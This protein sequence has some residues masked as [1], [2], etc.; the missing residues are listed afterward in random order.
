M[1]K[2]TSCP[3]CNGQ[4][5]VE[6]QQMGLAPTVMHEIFPGVE[7]PVAIISKYD[8]CQNCR[9]IFQNPRLGNKEV[10]MFYK[11][12]FY[13]R[14]LNLTEK[15]MSDDE[16]NRA[17]IDSKII[18]KHSGLIRSHLDIGCGRGYLL[19]VVNAPVKIGV[20]ADSMYVKSK[21][22]TL[23]SKISQVKQAS[24][25]LVTAIHVLEHVPDPMELL[26]YM[27]NK[28]SKNGLLVIEVPTW[29]SPGGPLRF[30]HLFHFETDVL[31]LLCQ[32]VGLKVI[33]VEFTPHLL[34]LCKLI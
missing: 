2:L 31:K 22:I 21:G 11:G 13:R 26:K 14:S 12:G 4:N 27:K 6:F 29:N 18:K 1:A 32:E 3:I 20:E 23:Y 10:E 34:L 25:D 24:F 33:E 9:V 28:V 15:R 16:K 8:V 7:I 17:I 19:K 5:F 30:S